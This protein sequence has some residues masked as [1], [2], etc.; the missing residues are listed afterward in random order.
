MRR[1]QDWASEIQPKTCTPKPGRDLRQLMQTNSGNLV[2]AAKN[3]TDLVSHARSTQTLSSQ[4]NSAA[5]VQLQRPGQDHVVDV[6]AMRIMQLQRNTSQ[7]SRADW[8]LELTHEEA[9]QLA[10]QGHD[11][12]GSS[13][14]NVRFHSASHLLQK[15]HESAAAAGD[16]AIDE[17]SSWDSQDMRSTDV[18]SMQ[19]EGLYAAAA[20]V[21][22]AMKAAWKK[23]MQQTH[24]SL[25]NKQAAVAQRTSNERTILPIRLLQCCQG[26]TLSDVEAQ[27]HALGVDKHLQR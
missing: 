4:P 1:T 25:S 16:M 17:S 8:Q 27:M 10:A 3:A 26:K 9:L 7:G 15:G 18:G 6:D 21:P 14:P 5:P 22:T 12:L 19:N 20:Q 23:E 24:Q 13:D 11:A 2:V